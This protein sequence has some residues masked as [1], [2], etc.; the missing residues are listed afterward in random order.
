MWRKEKGTERVNC[1]ACGLYFNTKGKYRDPNGKAM[2]S[3]VKK[4]PADK[5]STRELFQVT[6]CNLI[7]CRASCTNFLFFA[8]IQAHALLAFFA[9]QGQW[10]EQAAKQLGPA[11]SPPLGENAPG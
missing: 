11:E 3:G 4:T 6:C 1:N 10:W 8:E 9:A 5:V 2:R 7:Q